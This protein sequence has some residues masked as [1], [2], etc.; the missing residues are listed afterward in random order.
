MSASKQQ[1]STEIFIEIAKGNIDALK[2][3]M[4]DARAA[5]ISNRTAVETE[6][7]STPGKAATRSPRE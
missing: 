1:A 6:S 7:G 2:G 4:A 5:V 3:V